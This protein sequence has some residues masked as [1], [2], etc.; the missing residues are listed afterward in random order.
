MA[1]R[2]TRAAVEVTYFCDP[3]SPWAYAASPA[4]AQLR[5]RYGPQL[6]FHLVLI[7]LWANGAER[8]AIGYTPVG[9]ARGNRLMRRF[10]MPFSTVPRA[11]V[12]GSARACR[13]VVA[14]RERYPGLEHQVLRALQF[15]F[16]T[17]G[18]EVDTDE[19]IEC[20]LGHLGGERAA[21]LVSLL[22]EPEIGLAYRADRSRARSAA[23]SPSQAI[24]RT[25]DVNGVARYTAPTLIFDGPGGRLEAGGFQPADSYELALAHVG[26]KLERRPSAQTAWQVLERVGYP[27]TTYELAVCMAP[28]LTPPDTDAA[29]DELVE[30]AAEGTVRRYAAG[31]A[32]LWRLSSETPKAPA[33]ARS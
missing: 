10:G 21:E 24:G 29:E 22:D 33:G 14:A 3:G 4:L 28:P 23:G 8:E 9:T 1:E 25:D 16:F 31:E 27:L 15:A 18:L 6:R 5:Y 20:A 11:R 12:L 26:A 19:G 30:L 17:T 2:T 32:I 13:A 7:G